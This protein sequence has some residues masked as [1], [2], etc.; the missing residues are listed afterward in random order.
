MLIVDGAIVAIACGRSVSQAS[1]TQASDT[2][3]MCS[4]K[5]GPV[6]VRT[7][8]HRCSWELTVRMQKFENIRFRPFI[9]ICFLSFG[10]KRL[11]YTLLARSVHVAITRAQ[12]CATPFFLTEESRWS[13]SAVQEGKKKNRPVAPG[14]LSFPGQ[15]VA[16]YRALLSLLLSPFTIEALILRF[17]PSGW[18]SSRQR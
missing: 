10:N 3:M 17:A 2:D 12:A 8:Q 18:T 6:V 16:R 7:Y 15:P 5:A 1:H 14:H 9:N 13:R 11:D 4:R